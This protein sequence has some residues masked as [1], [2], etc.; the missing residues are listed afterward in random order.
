MNEGALMAWIRAVEDRSAD[1]H[2]NPEGKV[3]VAL[4]RDGGVYVAS[5]YGVDLAEAVTDALEKG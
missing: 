4:Y 5:G 2:I 1:I 3:V